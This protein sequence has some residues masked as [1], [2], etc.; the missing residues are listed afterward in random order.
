MNRLNESFINLFFLCLDFILII[1]LT[2]VVFVGL[3]LRIL[4]IIVEDIISL[5]LRR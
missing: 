4:Y 5:V 3:F 2:F 1:F